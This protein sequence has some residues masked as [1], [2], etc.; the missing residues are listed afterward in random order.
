MHHDSEAHA[1]AALITQSVFLDEMEPPM[2]RLTHAQML[3]GDNMISRELGYQDAMRGKA[4]EP[5]QVPKGEARAA[6]SAGYAR[7]EAAKAR[8]SAA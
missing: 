1:T 3:V 2:P 4:L 5:G 6:Y 7:G 8:A